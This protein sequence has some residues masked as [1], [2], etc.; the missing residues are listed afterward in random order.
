MR[1]TD[2]QVYLSK[3]SHRSDW[4][5]LSD[6]FSGTR[7]QGINIRHQLSP[8]KWSTSASYVADAGSGLPGNGQQ[9]HLASLSTLI[10]TLFISPAV[11]C[12][13]YLYLY[14]NLALP[15]AHSAPDL[16]NSPVFVKQLP[17]ISHPTSHNGSSS[18]SHH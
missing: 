2:S 3:S 14:R 4:V 8:A 1:A 5:M 12:S 7:P 10:S 15:F 11:S 13:I 18:F 6:V 17:R 16:Y 9:L